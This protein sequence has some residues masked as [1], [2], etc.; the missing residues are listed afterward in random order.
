MYALLLLKLLCITPPDARSWQ[1]S[2]TQRLITKTLCVTSTW[3]MWLRSQGPSTTAPQQLLFFTCLPYT[4][5][6]PG[7]PELARDPSRSNTAWQYRALVLCA[8]NS[9]QWLLVRSS[10]LLASTWMQGDGRVQTLPRN[11][12]L[13]NGLTQSTRSWQEGYSKAHHSLAI[14]LAVS[15]G[16]LRITSFIPQQRCMAA[17]PATMHH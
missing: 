15:A 16:Q 3:H 1:E 8:S 7:S 13:L 17:S 14:I 11:E 10:S 6:H 9:N 5:H 12:Q 4:P 2:H